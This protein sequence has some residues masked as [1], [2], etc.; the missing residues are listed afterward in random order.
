M[1]LSQLANPRILDQPVYEPGKP[2]EEVA[3]EYGLNLDQ[4]CKL[5]SNENPWGAS[6]LAKEAARASLEKVHLY[7]DGS[8]HQLINKLASIHLLGADQ[9]VLGNGSNEI[10]ELL[11]H[12]FLQ[13]GD[14][15]LCGKHAFVVY[16]LVALLMGAK[17]VE[18]E[19]PGLTH[20]LNKMR[21]AVNERTK[22]I[23]LPSPNNPTGTANTEEEIHTFVRSLPQ[24]VIFCFDEAY[25]EYLDSPPDLRPLIEEGHKVICLRTFSK[26]HGLAALRIGYGY[27]AKEMIALLQRARQPFN[28]NAIAQAAALGALQDDHW[29]TQCR[30][31]N[32]DGLEQLANGLKALGYR[33]PTQPGKL[34]FVQARRR[35]GIVY[36]ITKAGY[37]HSG[38]GPVSCS[39]PSPF[40]WHR[41]RKPSPPDRS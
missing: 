3:R 38:P 26:I 15:V 34:Y 36:R 30:K 19:M 28:V 31:R 8:G 17:P 27:G 5:A 22:L 33:V 35:A 37:N 18:V 2:I 7:P 20:D 13:P 40:C 24:H 1:N 39:L 12:V 14:E 10:I 23:F 25:A 11:G 29:V 16:K 6:K 21:Q 4:I 9:F 41:R 32:T